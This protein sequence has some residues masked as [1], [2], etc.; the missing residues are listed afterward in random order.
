MK[1]IM[2][3][4]VA[5]LMMSVSMMAQESVQS[6]SKK[7]CASIEQC[8]KA[9]GMSVAECLA[10]CAK[11]CLKGDK[12]CC[13]KKLGGQTTTTQTASASSSAEVILIGNEITPAKAE[14]SCTKAEKAAC[15]KKCTKAQQA[16]CAKKC[17]KGK[18]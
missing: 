11:Q 6:A 18:V 10:S 9:N 15:A 5:F 7:C 16:A 12:K 8:A 1:R 4:A 3:L 2:L 13:L 14:R 17:K